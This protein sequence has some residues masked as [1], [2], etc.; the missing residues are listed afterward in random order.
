[1]KKQL[2]SLLSLM[3]CMAASAQ[4]NSPNG[5]NLFY[6]NG[7]ADIT[8]RF[9]ER[10]NGGRAFVHDGG[11]ALTLNYEGDFTGGTKIASWFHVANNGNFRAN[12]WQ[13]Y[14]SA[15]DDFYVDVEPGTR[16]LRTRN[17]NTGSPNIAATGIHTGTGLFEGYVGVGTTSPMNGLHVFSLNNPQGGSI[18]FGHSG[19]DDAVLSFGYNGID[20]D[21]LKIGKFSHNSN[22]NETTFMTMKTSNGN[23]G[24][25]TLDPDEKLTVKGGIHARSVKVDLNGPLADYVF[26]ADY[27]LRSLTDLHT[28][29]KRFHHLPEVPSAQ[30]AQ[31]NGLDLGTMNQAL[32]KKVEE[33]T[34]YVIHQSKEIKQMKT[35]ILKLKNKPQTKK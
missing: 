11:N 6:Y 4:I 20:Q 7:L 28:Y 1:M 5:N 25:G 13:P 19:S 12:S 30:E 16:L 17:W 24:I 14:G 31:S 15:S 21:V 33:L 9:Q 10:G 2:L 8:F 32:L 18:R 35:Q 29:I 27:K 23:V 34:L 26:E 22:A 3:G